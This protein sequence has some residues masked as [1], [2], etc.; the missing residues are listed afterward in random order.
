MY[1][2]LSG[3]VLDFHILNTLKTKVKLWH[4][5]TLFTLRWHRWLKTW[6]AFTRLSYTV[7]NAA[8]DDLAMQGAKASVAMVLKYIPRNIH[9]Q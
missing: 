4:L 5:L 8:N 3:M 1:D 9:I 2:N 7:N 6:M